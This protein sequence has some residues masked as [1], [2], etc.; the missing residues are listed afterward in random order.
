MNQIFMLQVSAMFHI[1]SSKG[2]P[3]IPDHLSAE[4]REFI[5]LCFDRHVTQSATAPLEACR[6]LLTFSMAIFE[7][8]VLLAK[9]PSHTIR[10]FTGHQIS[11]FTILVTAFA[12]LCCSEILDKDNLVMI[13]DTYQ[14]PNC[15][16]IV[17]A[18][19][20]G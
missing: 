18:P 12:Y 11:H 2:P 19:I 4:A 14:S 13:Q 9:K 5:L 10:H 15:R 8:T 6:R 16:E 20:S 7:R 17:A 1:A 3:P